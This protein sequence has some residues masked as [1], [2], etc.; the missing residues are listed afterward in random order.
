MVLQEDEKT[1]DWLHLQIMPVAWKCFRVSALYG[2]LAGII[3]SLIV[4]ELAPGIPLTK[5]IIIVCTPVLIGSTYLI[6]STIYRC[7]R[8]RWELTT[9]EIR[10]RGWRRFNIP[11]KRLE[12]IESRPVSDLPG[13]TEI[14]VFVGKSPDSTGIVVSL[15]EDELRAMFESM[16]PQISWI[17][18]E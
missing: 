9:K 1:R 6:N 7:F 12:R 13:Y 15:R 16:H 4:H 5:H 11:W 10:V 3:A 17:H 8:R 18:T 2:S 14:R